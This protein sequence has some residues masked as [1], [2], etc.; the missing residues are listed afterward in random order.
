MLSLGG[1]ALGFSETQAG[2]QPPAA[3]R[4]VRSRFDTRTLDIVLGSHELVIP[5]AFEKFCRDC[6]LVA[7]CVA[8]AC[9]CHHGSTQPLADRIFLKYVGLL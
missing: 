5:A 3:V 4:S 7:R 8:H 6:I 1:P 9:V 2:V